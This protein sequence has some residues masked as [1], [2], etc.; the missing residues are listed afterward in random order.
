MNS[1]F[2]KAALQDAYIADF[3]GFDSAPEF[4]ASLSHRVRMHR[5]FSKF[6]GAPIPETK[7]KFNRRIAAVLLI[8]I[9]MAAIA[10][11]TGVIISNFTFRQHSDNVEVEAAGTG[12]SQIEDIYCIPSLPDGFEL[13]NEITPEMTGGAVY[14][15][16]YSCGDELI[17]FTQHTKAIY[18]VSFDN[19]HGDFEE[20]TV[21]G[22]S[23][24]FLGGYG[25][26]NSI[27]WDNGDYILELSATLP[28]DESIALA[29]SVKL[30][31]KT[32][33]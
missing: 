30:A 2:L 4:R 22:H 1:E 11:C 9:F 23:A 7:P 17:S 33:K 15:V 10:G 29:D 18:N 28:K 25:S 13:T 32:D 16:T 24:L 6:Y 27:V 31:Q 20:I 12:K 3:S 5:I 21:G 8:I 14:D 26:V 19:E